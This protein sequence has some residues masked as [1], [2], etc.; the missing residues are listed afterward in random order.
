MILLL[1]ELAQTKPTNAENTPRIT[2]DGL[3]FSHDARMT[4]QQ[5]IQKSG[6]KQVSA[7]KSCRKLEN[8]LSFF[9]RQGPF[10]LGPAALVHPGGVPHGTWTAGRPA[11]GPGE[12]PEIFLLFGA[13]T[14]FFLV[15]WEEPGGK[16]SPGRQQRRNADP[17]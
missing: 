15:L 14:G 6:H 10:W 5:N 9:R 11:E 8:A 1:A 3:G 17:I 7:G 4:E 2:L 13:Q 12:A 16:K